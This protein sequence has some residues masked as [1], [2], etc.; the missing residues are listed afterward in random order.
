MLPAHAGGAAGTHETREHLLPHVPCPQAAC[1][2][3][4]SH[5]PALSCCS[6]VL[7]SCLLSPLQN[8]GQSE[9]PDSASELFVLRGRAACSSRDLYLIRLGCYLLAWECEGLV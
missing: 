6:A 2:H 5:T 1:C 4:F 9:S 8:Q 7:L 3:Q